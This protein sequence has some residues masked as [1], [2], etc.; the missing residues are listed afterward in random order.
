MFLRNLFFLK[1]FL[2]PDVAVWE[3]VCDDDDDDVVEAVDGFG[4]LDVERFVSDI[5]L[6]AAEIS[7]FSPTITVHGFD[8]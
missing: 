1:R 6:F 2:P 8:V 3:F 4:R 5:T 7:E